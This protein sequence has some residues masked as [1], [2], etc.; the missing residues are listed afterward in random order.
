[1]RNTSVTFVRKVSENTRTNTQFYRIII[2]SGSLPRLPTS[3]S[4]MVH[5]VQIIQRNQILTTVEPVCAK[6]VR[7]KAP[8]LVDFCAFLGIAGDYRSYIVHECECGGLSLSGQKLRL[9]RPI[10]IGIMM[11]FGRSDH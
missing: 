1:M 10:Y 8:W 2:G 11:S 7:V 4:G 6:S 3:E 5:S 9:L